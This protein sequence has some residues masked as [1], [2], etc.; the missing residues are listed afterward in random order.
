M[1]FGGFFSNKKVL[2]ISGVGTLIGAG[3]LVK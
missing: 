2:W 3:I 1:S